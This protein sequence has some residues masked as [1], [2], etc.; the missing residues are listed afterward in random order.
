MGTLKFYHIQPK[1]GL[2]KLQRG[3]NTPISAD[4]LCFFLLKK[5]VDKNWTKCRISQK[6]T[7]SGKN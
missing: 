3:V 6:F 2:S 7:F 5:E 1:K 4:H